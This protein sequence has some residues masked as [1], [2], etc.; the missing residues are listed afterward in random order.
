[1]TER[2]IHLALTQGE[3]ETI[4]SGLAMFKGLCMEE[5]ARDGLDA[6]DA[7]LGKF[8]RA[9]AEQVLGQE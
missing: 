3:A 8:Y 4:L 6:C 5:R 1:V 9:I 2:E 7:V